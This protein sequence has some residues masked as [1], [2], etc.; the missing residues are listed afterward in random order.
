MKQ[1]V[2][3]QLPFPISPKQE[4]KLQQYVNLLLKWNKAFNL[5]GR[6]TED[7]IWQR[8]ILDAAQLAPLL[9]E[10]KTVLDVGCGAGLPSVVLAILGEAHITACER[11]QKKTDFIKEVRRNLSLEEKLTVLS[12]DVRELKAQGKTF[13]I[14]TAR[15]VAPLVELVD[16]T[17]GLLAVGGK[18]VFPKGAEVQQELIELSAK[19]N[20]TIERVSSITSSTGEIILLRE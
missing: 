3:S 18:Y 20:M 14:I 5:I 6:S 19:Y 9:G 11:I 16:L 7:D 13:E 10:A 8:H 4:E 12:Q 15:A 2:L 1:H 17:E